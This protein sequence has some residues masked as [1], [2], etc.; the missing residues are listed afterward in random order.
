M[1]NCTSVTV[2]LCFV[3]RV[4]IYNI[5]LYLFISDYNAALTELLNTRENE[6]RTLQ[7]EG[8]VLEYINS[9]I[10]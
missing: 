4:F 1:K 3:A 10:M 7:L 8:A 9:A 2:Q 6:L 5:T